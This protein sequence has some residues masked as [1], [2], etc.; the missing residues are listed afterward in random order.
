MVDTL[1]AKL[2]GEEIIVRPLGSVS[3][4]TDLKQDSLTA[5]RE[6]GVEIIL[7]GTIQT[8]NNRIRISAQL[9]RAS[10]GK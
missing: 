4:Y 1:I 10:D 9:L 2:G 3:R 6:L 8:A 5:G 7:D